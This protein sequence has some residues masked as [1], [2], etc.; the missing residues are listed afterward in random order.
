MA[1]AHSTAT[2]G[3]EPLQVERTRTSS[4]WA[5][6]I[7]ALVFLILLIVFIAQN[8]RSE[9]LHF[10]GFSGHVS[11]ALALLIAAVVGA[12]FVVL[13]GT[14]RLLQLR[15]ATR[16]HNRSVARSSAGPTTS[17]DGPSAAA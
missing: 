12:A 4:V 2:D 17:T 15:L 6:I 14:A 10:L 16:R 1:R 8:N 5:A 13:V 9:P 11:E 3:H 7:I